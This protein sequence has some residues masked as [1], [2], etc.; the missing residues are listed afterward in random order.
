MDA[1]RSMSNTFLIVLNVLD[2]VVL[3]LLAVEFLYVAIISLL[4]ILYHKH[5]FNVLWSSRLTICASVIIW[6]VRLTSLICCNAEGLCSIGGVD[7][8]LCAVLVELG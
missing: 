1:K 2:L 7:L 4:V 3:G 8:W 6:M 5:P